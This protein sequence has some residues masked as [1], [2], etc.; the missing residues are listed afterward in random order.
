[1][2]KVGII[3]TKTSNIFSLIRYLE[4]NNISYKIIENSIEVKNFGHIIIPGVGSFGSAMQ[5]LKLNNMID[6]LN[7]FVQ[8]GKYLM[9]IC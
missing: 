7:D 4:H 1:M 3:N 8:K 9:G 6:K 2:S 5:L